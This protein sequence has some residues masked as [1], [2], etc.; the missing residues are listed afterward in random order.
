MRTSPTYR[1]ALSLA[2][3][4]KPRVKEAPFGLSAPPQADSISLFLGSPKSRKDWILLGIRFLTFMK[5]YPSSVSTETERRL[6]SKAKK[7]N[8]LRKDILPDIFALDI[9]SGCGWRYS[10]WYKNNSHSLLWL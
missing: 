4:K 3:G 7:E 6:G 8:D 5:R 2:V 1:K 10:I 9:A